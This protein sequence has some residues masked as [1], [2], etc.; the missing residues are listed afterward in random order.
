[1]GLGQFLDNKKLND[2]LDCRSEAAAADREVKSR[3]RPSLL[4]DV[5]QCFGSQIRFGQDL[6][7]GIRVPVALAALEVDV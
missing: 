5:A 2:V 1:M 3:K 6:Q 7:M 4:P